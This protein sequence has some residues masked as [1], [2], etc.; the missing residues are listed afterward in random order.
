MINTKMF[1]SWCKKRLT[2]RIVNNNMLILKYLLGSVHI[3]SVDDI[4]V[5]SVNKIFE[6]IFVSDSVKDSYG[7]DKNIFLDNK[8]FWLNKCIYPSCLESELNF[9]SELNWPN[10]RFIKI[11]SKN[12]KAKVVERSSTRISYHTEYDL[13]MFIDR[14]IT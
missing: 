3:N 4:W 13:Y 5:A 7:Y 14:D 2:S 11:I 6:Y 9:I 1:N 12:G 10:K 8:N